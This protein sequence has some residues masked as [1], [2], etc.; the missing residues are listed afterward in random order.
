MYWASKKFCYV[1]TFIIAVCFHFGV[2]ILKIKSKC[3]YVYTCLPMYTKTHPLVSLENVPIREPCL[4]L[5][6]PFSQHQYV[7][8]G[9]PQA[10]T[11]HTCCCFTLTHYI[12]MLFNC[13]TINLH[14][15]CVVFYSL[16]QHVMCCFYSLT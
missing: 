7:P 16:V 8:Q 12:W 6:D 13:F 14:T 2:S 10:L 5:V 9:Q 4:I 1:C 3:M 15:L 11:H